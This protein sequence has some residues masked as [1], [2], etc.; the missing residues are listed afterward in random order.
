M[1]DQLAH[2]FVSGALGIA[3][4]GRREEE[5]LHVDDEEGCF[6][7]VE[8]D[9]VCG[10]LEG[11]A[12][13]DWRGGW[14]WRVGEVEAGGGVVEPEVFAGKADDCWRSGGDLVVGVGFGGHRCGETELKLEVD[15]GKVVFSNAA[16]CRC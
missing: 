16:V 12:R 4:E 9:G 8:G 7:G 3:A 13:V 10:C 14:C 11:E 15:L 2:G 5:V 1:L 6:G